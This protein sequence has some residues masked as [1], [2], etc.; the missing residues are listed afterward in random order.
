MNKTLSQKSIFKSRKFALLEAGIEMIV[1]DQKIEQTA[2]I[3]FEDIQRNKRFELDKVQPNYG[4]YVITRN[5]G[6]LCFFLKLFGAIDS[7]SWCLALLCSSVI[8]FL[9]HIYTVGRYTI[10]ETTDENELRF[11]SDLPDN[12]EVENFFEKMYNE[13]Y[14]YLRKEY[15]ENWT[16]N[17]SNSFEILEWLY[18]EKIINKQEYDDRIQFI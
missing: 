13:R 1:R 2:F 3:R 5:A 4:L 18:S 8:F 6:I 12:E 16:Q 9:I 11:Y 14:Q 10:I 7:W 17:E 15:F